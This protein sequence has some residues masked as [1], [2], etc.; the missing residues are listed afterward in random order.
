MPAHPRQLLRTKP[1][2]WLCCHLMSTPAAP[3]NSL[4]PRRGPR[5]TPRDLCA[6]PQTPLRAVPGGFT[7]IYAPACASSCWLGPQW[8]TKSK[9][10]PFLW[11]S[12]PKLPWKAI[13]LLEGTLN[14]TVRCNSNFSTVVTLDQYSMCNTPAWPGL[15]NHPISE[16]PVSSFLEICGSW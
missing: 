16:S 8:A 3:S 14:L 13:N 4:E 2:H 12:L 15:A 6:H 9:H 7:V 1:N 5:N 10:R 11:R